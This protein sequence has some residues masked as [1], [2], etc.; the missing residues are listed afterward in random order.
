M[1]VVHIYGKIINCEEIRDVEIKA[2]EYVHIHYKNP[3]SPSDYTI[4]SCAN[5]KDAKDVMDII[6]NE[7]I[8]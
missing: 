7:M 4:I 3:S 6:Y 1:K 8:P 2:L 5:E